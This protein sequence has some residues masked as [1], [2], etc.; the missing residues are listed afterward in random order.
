MTD[1]RCLDSIPYDV[2]YYITATLDCRDFINLSRVNRALNH[3]LGSEPIARKAIEVFPLAV[4][5]LVAVSI[6]LLTELTDRTTC[7][8][9]KAT[10]LTG[11]NPAIAVLSAACLTPKRPFPLHSHTPPP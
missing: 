3:A 7:T 10:R 5:L 6:H 1:P 11:L 2:F 9:K 8:P 4:F